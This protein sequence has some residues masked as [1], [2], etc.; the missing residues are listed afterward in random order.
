MLPRMICVPISRSSRGS[1]AF[2]LPCV[3]TDMKTGVSTTPCGVVN[4]PRR[5]LELASVL[6]SSNMVRMVRYAAGWGNGKLRPP[7]AGSFYLAT[8]GGVSPARTPAL[9]CQFH[10]HAFASGFDLELAFALGDELAGVGEHLGDLGVV[11]VAGVVMEQEELF[12]FRLDGQR[13]HVVQA[14][15]APTGVLLVF[16]RI[17]LSVHDQHVGAAQEVDQLA[18]LA[19]VPEDCSSLSGKKAMEASEVN[20]R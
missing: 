14:A 3:P 10:R 5:A 13:D 16:L 9:L 15:V 6:S 20:K 11:V 18:A 8:F 12:H 17:K 4:R 1:I 7:G 19:R 2:T